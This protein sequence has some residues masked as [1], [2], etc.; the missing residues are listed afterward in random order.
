MKRGMGKAAEGESGWKKRG[1][2]GQS[3]IE[4]GE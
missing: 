3:R 1:K 4:K 2:R